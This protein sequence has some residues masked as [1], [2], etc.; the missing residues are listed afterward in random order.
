VADGSSPEWIVSWGVPPSE[1]DAPVKDV[2]VVEPE[3][4]ADPPVYVGRVVR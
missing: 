4:E 1:L 3:A 2:R